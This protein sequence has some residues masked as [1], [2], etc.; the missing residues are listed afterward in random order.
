M[1]PRERDSLH[2]LLDKS[3][4]YRERVDILNHMTNLSFGDAPEKS[5]QFARTMVRTASD[6]DY[7]EGM[8]MGSLQ[9]GRAYA[10]LGSYDKAF[11]VLANA[12]QYYAQLNDLNNEASAINYMANVLYMG[13][14]FQES[15]NYFRLCLEIKKQVND[16]VGIAIAYSNIGECYLQLEKPDS[17]LYYS[18]EGLRVEHALG[19]RHGIAV[20]QSS[21]AHI[22]TLRGN[23]EEAIEYYQRASE[24][25]YEMNDL[26]QLAHNYA[27]LSQVY[28]L[29]N[30]PSRALTYIEQGMTY[31]TQVKSPYLS[32]EFLKLF[33]RYFEMAK[34]TEKALQ[35]YKKYDHLKDSLFRQEA[36]SQM[37]ELKTIYD[38]E[39]KEKEITLLS[40]ENALH[41]MLVFSA[42][43]VLGLFLL[44]LLF[45]F[46]QYRLKKKSA[47]MLEH[48]NRE[49]ASQQSEI[50]QKHQQLEKLTEELQ[51]IDELKSRFFTNIS[52]EFRTPLT[53]I[54]GP[55]EQ[56]LS[57]QKEKP[58]ARTLSLAIRNARSLLGLINQLL[59]ISRFEKGMVKLKLQK[60]CISRQ[61][62]FIV[63][64][65]ASKAYEKGLKLDFSSDADPLEGYFDKEKLANILINLVSNALKNTPKG[66]IC[67]HL[68]KNNP[69]GHVR[70]SVSDTGYGIPP[71]DL[72]RIFDRFY[73][74]NNPAGEVGTG[75]GLA[76]TK[77]IVNACKG[78]IWVESQ[79]NH[80]TTFFVE[81]PVSLEHF[82]A[83]GFELINP[84]DA[85]ET[86]ACDRVE[87]EFIIPQPDEQAQGESLKTVLL[88]ED[89][90]E[91][92]E[93]MRD[94]LKGMYH[95]M[96]AGNG[97]TGF[98]LACNNFP[99]IIITDVTMPRVDGIELAKKLKKN[100]ETNHI[101]VIMLTAKASEQSKLEGLATQVDD[102]LTKPFSM[103]ELTARIRNLLAIRQKLQEKY[104]R[105]LTVNPSEITSNS[106]DEQFISR[107]LKIVEEHMSN[108]EFSVEVLCLEA[109]M[110]RSTLHK[111]LRSLLNQ[112][113]TEFI[114]TIRVKRAAQ[115]I[116]Q[117]AGSISEIAYDVGFSNL[118]YFSRVFK[119]C[120]GMSPSE[121][122]NL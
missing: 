13:N 38:L 115:L 75:I 70:L 105:A 15:L 29:K 120:L 6:Y 71:Q 10:M 8:A 103:R 85:E 24:V 52:H 102:Y 104:K 21:I 119:K 46:R 86:I 95:I 79:L 44:L 9:M 19:N 5:L 100:P 108:P 68:E 3:R 97:E 35:Y 1:A 109:N 96:E 122:A 50:M 30:M 65:F 117:N 113:A 69:S 57:S 2:I 83:A 111:K 37:A 116:K 81:L 25:F 107:V 16:S 121:M 18:M 42:S 67:V 99:D 43:I 91:L 76:F 31:A 77:E 92:R 41:K 14:Y 23:Y 60:G 106:I 94:H 80:G 7:I 22:L 84:A 61:V 4:D 12:R 73:M 78:K 20:S 112:S 98:D 74:G 93:F 88:V 11:E 47:L 114:N 26:T 59:E 101:P 55:L 87:K 34:Q 53:L 51:E 58:N 54:I 49:I 110:S 40:K 89:H 56:L 90:D 63:Q 82:D 32:K 64:M 62:D 17:A 33:S 45:I 27:D 36:R 66:Q 118:S 48:K 28:L 39:S 72:P